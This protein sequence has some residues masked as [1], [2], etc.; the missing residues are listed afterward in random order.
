[1]STTRIMLA[2]LF[3]AALTALIVGLCTAGLAEAAGPEPQSTPVAQTPDC[4]T[5]H[6]DR[7]QQ[8][9]ASKHAAAFSNPAFK[10][11]WDEGKN[12]QYCLACHT[13]G[14]DANTGQY[15]QDGV[16]CTACH[17]P[18]GTNPHPGGAMTVSD[19]AEFCG[20]CHTTTLHE[21]QQ[22]GHGKA[23]VA[24]KSCHDMH[25]T[26]L[27]TTNSD[28]L[29]SNCHKER[30]VQ[31]ANM[32]MNATTQCANCH[33]LTLSES[34]VEGKGATGHSF[35]MN[36]D[37]CQLCH[38]ENIHEAHKISLTSPPQPGADKAITPPPSTPASTPD[39]IRNSSMANI[40]VGALGG[41]LFGFAAAVVVVR[42]G[43]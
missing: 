2:I 35:A 11:T 4:A 16:G 1:M 27:R 13:T 40:G 14:F 30:N 19:S 43:Q 7:A 12:Q 10:K 37:A 42:R 29:C 6:S 5:C 15:A 28:D 36:S 3:V 31:L 39:S 32:P 33:M 25:S 24:C 38:K 9:Q 41:L 22:G 17:K 18:S 34:K 20:T 21:W 26:T 8:W 23:N